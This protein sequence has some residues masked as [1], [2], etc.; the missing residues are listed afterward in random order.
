VLDRA[1]EE[2][3]FQSIEKFINENFDWPD[4][5]DAAVADIRGLLKSTP[6]SY[7]AQRVRNVD[8]KPGRILDMGCG[9]GRWTLAMSSIFD[10]VVGIDLNRDR[11]RLANYVVERLGLENVKFEERSILGLP[12]EDTSFDSIVCYGVVVASDILE[13]ALREMFRVLKPSG[14]AYVTLNGGGWNYMLRDVSSKIHEQHG[15]MGREGIYNTV[16]SNNFRDLRKALK[17]SRDETVRSILD[18][19]EQKFDPGDREHIRRLDALIYGLSRGTVSS[20]F[21]QTVS[22][23]RK[24]AGEEFVETFKGDLTNLLS[25][26]TNGFSYNHQPSGYAPE[27]AEAV[28]KEVGFENFTWDFEGKLAMTQESVELKPIYATTHM[29]DEL[30]V[31]DFRVVKP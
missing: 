5:V 22:A 9:T 1:S 27:Y 20:P 29:N 11:I 3:S 25:G 26:A 23:L 15:R 13:D 17:S 24:S 28:C 18:S 16:V 4:G 30:V 21:D 8:L 14:V 19:P 7:C 10:E 6:L 31:W 2:I 12:Y